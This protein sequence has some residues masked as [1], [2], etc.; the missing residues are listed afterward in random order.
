MLSIENLSAGYGKAS[1][2]KDVSLEMKSHELVA[3][4]GPNGAGKSTLLKTITGLNSTQGGKIIFQGEPMQTLTPDTRVRKGICLVPEGRQ[5]FASFTVEDNLRLGMY[6]Y[7]HRASKKE[8][9]DEFSRIY[10]IFPILE[11]RKRQKAGTLS[12]G[13]Q[14]MLAI[15]RSLM[16]R[17]KLLLLDEPS[18]GLAP[19][20]V[21]EIFR[22][23][24]NL[25]EMGLPVLIVEQNA[26]AVLKISHRAYVL[27]HG[28]IV[29]GGKSEELLSAPA[30]T[31]AYLGT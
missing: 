19:L 14:Q 2:L 29:F 16:A 28:K 15:G 26:N 22:I 8:I 12:G 30:L 20:V 23:I 13:E 5:V 7:Y 4:I 31:K 10:K 21:K 11:Q 24:V 27:D 6:A 3:L 1:V 25:Y 9:E 18:L 17:P